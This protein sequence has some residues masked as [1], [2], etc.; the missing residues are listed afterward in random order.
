MASTHFVLQKSTN[1]ENKR[2]GEQKTCTK[3][4]GTAD[5][6][7]RE[8]FQI[9]FP[10]PVKGE[11]FAKGTEKCKILG[12]LKDKE[13]EKLEDHGCPKFK[14]LVDEAAWICSSY[15]FKHKIT[16]HCAECKLELF[17]NLFLRDLML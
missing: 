8:S 10:S 4:C 1:P 14:D 2:F 12:I 3:L 9:N 7:I 13:V 16:L 15:L 11:H 5:V 17:G 6:W